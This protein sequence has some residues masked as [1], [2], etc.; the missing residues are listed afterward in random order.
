MSEASAAP[1]GAGE[2][3]RPLPSPEGQAPMAKAYQPAEVEAAVY[4]RWLAADV[5]APDGAGSRAR[6]TEAPFVVIMPPPNVTGALHLGHAARSATEDLMVRRARM[7][8]RPTLWLPGVDHAS[9]AAQ[10]VLR[11]VLA[12]EG[13]T[14]EELGRER[15]LERMW[16]FM[17][18]TRPVI[19]GQQRRLGISA[20]WGRERFTMDERSARA[21]RVAFKRL[22]EDGLAYRGQKLVNWCPG[23]GTSVSDLEVIGTPETGKLWSIRYHLLPEGAAPG[24]EPSTAETITVAT[25]RP[26]TI[27][28]DTAVAVHPEDPRYAALVGRLVRIPF[29]DRDVPIIADGFVERDFGTGA[30]KVTPA[31]DHTDFATGERHGLPRVDV[32]TDDATMNE[33]AGPYAGLTREAC[34]ERILADLEA[35]GDLA[36]TVDHELAIGRCQRSDDIV[37]PRLK[38]QWFIDVKPMADRAM[39]AVREGRTRFVPERF[40]KVFFDWLENIYDWNVSRQLWWG[41]RIPAWYCP[42]GHVTVSDEERG[43]ERCV[44][45]ASSALTQDDDTFD[46]W[47]SSGLW[48]FSTLGWPDETSDLRTFYPTTVME[49]AHDILFFWVARM[50]MLGEWLTGE[51]PFSVV[52]LSGLIRDPYGKKMSKTKGNVIDPLAIMDDIGADA[53]RFALVNGAAPGADQRLG[54]S[55]LEGARNFANKLWNAARF[56]LGA[57]PEEVPAEAT[58]AL[59]ERELLGPAEHWILSRCQ[60]AVRD[61]EAAYANFQFAE[62]SRILHTAIWSEYCDWYLEMAKVRLGADA[63]P[64]AR[65]ATWQVL[66]WVLDRYLRMLHPVMPHITEEIWGRLPHRADDGDLLI[67]AAWP[68]QDSWAAETEEAQASAVADLLELVT[69]IRNARADAGIEPG[70]WLQA[71]VRFDDERTAEVFEA[72]R[73]TVARLARVRP[74]LAS[75]TAEP[76]TA[77]AAALVVVARGA[78]A[79]LSVSAEDRERDRARLQKELD[80][81]ERL[82]ASTRAKLANEAFVSRAPA[83]VVEGVR[84]TE[85]ELQGLAAR[86]REHLEA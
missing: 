3:S 19:M 76:A 59:P 74:T 6:S 4:A 18:E 15:Y 46:T 29:V 42:D 81:A 64:A 22:Y 14:P 1:S 11:R 48:P 7:Q 5:F 82:L 38:T 84:A 73:D 43:P 58:L 50:M 13:T 40:E 68:A 35:R 12:D 10:W 80:E 62:A 57:R 16:R 55:R 36:A 54:P 77:D 24:T 20:D 9:I 52:Y 21:V 70:T 71:D 32:M 67:T 41:H 33:L 72:L 61:A 65:V 51:E 44:E 56:V 37:E 25:T 66:A 30:V 47:F 2:A 86:L 63:D 85:A 49:T 45:C 83:H 69:Q 78:E 8:G 26:E 31:H 75:A 39:Q 79:R 27:L 17:E 60:A 34:R 23:C 53:L 28:G